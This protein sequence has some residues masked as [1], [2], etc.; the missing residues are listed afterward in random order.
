VDY[1]SQLATASRVYGHDIGFGQADYF[2]LMEASILSRSSL[3][4]PLPKQTK[5]LVDT[6]LAGGV[7]FSRPGVRGVADQ[8]LRLEWTMFLIT[9]SLLVD[10]QANYIMLELPA[11]QQDPKDGEQH[12]QKKC[13]A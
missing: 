9:G 13:H 7:T 8:R 2:V 11:F 10:Q 5:L 3:L 4:L 12:R 6:E 1:L